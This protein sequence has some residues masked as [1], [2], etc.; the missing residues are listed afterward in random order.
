[1]VKRVDLM[2]G[3][4]NSLKMQTQNKIKFKNCEIRLDIINTAKN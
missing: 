1:M 3:I 4:L 2:L